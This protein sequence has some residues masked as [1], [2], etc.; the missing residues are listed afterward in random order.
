MGNFAFALLTPQAIERQLAGVVLSRIM[1]RGNMTLTA[2]Q[3]IQFSPDDVQQ[4]TSVLPQ[5]AAANLTGSPASLLYVFNGENAV[6]KMAGLLPELTTSLGCANQ[7]LAAGNEAQAAAAL[8]VLAD[9]FQR[10]NL[11]TPAPAAGEERT[12]LIIK[13]E[14][15][16][17]VS[18]RPGAIIDMLMSLDLKWVG[19]KVHGMSIDEALEF[20]GPVKQA[21]RSK[22]GPKIGTQALAFLEEKLAMKFNN[23]S[24][25]AIVEAAGNGFADDQFEQIVEFMAGKRP[26]EVPEAERN[27][28]AGAKCMVLI[29]DGVN[30]V[31][32][33]R[34]ILGPTNPAQAPGGTVRCDFGTNIMINAS[35]ASDSV[36]SFER[37]GGIVKVNS[38]ALSQIL[39]DNL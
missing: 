27:L 2:S 1:A 15:F 16:R 39:R 6:N 26:S 17:Q 34:T 19:C 30:A 28:P 11:L 32:K 13:P 22:L 20:Y 24:A 37:E 14:N 31:S 23:S 21:L 5:A 25:D 33:I 9:I 10:D 12:L 8:P 29:F 35:H 4:L 3:L 38:N 7:I 36:E 18:V